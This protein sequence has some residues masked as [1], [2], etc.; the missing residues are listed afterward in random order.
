MLFYKYSFK[1][2]F[3]S[4]SIITTIGYG[5]VATKTIGGRVF[6]LL[7]G[8]VGI[9]FM[10]SVLADVGGLLAGV[11]QVWETSLKFRVYQEFLLYKFKQLPPPQRWPGVVIRSTHWSGQKG[12]GSWEQERLNFFFP[13]YFLSSSCHIVTGVS[14][15]HPTE[16]PHIRCSSSLKNWAPSCWSVQSLP[17][18]FFSAL[19]LCSLL[20]GRWENRAFH[21]HS[22][23]IESSKWWLHSKSLWENYTSFLLCHV[24][25]L[26]T[27][28]V[29]VTPISFKENLSH[30][31]SFLGVDFLWVILLL[32][33]YNDHHRLWR[34]N[35]RCVRCVSLLLL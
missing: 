3:F 11:M 27:G 32:L 8:I 34:F 1:A 4:L 22:I 17:S 25:L 26:R 31:I 18:S 14:S 6:C 9:P 10:L 20:S 30:S 23:F 24:P 12:W 2:C 13:K 19:E 33:H 21:T 7:F 15:F 29:C 16:C 28:F 5:N 35:S